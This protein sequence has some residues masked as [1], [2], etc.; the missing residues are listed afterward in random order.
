AFRLIPPSV[1]VLFWM[2]VWL[3][4]KEI[5]PVMVLPETSSPSPV[6]SIPPVIV[7]LSIE[8]LLRN[9]TVLLIVQ[10]E[11]VL[12]SSRPSDPIVQP[13]TILPLTPPRPRVSVL[14][15]TVQPEPMP[16][17]M[18][19]AWQF[20]TVLEEPTEKPSV[21][22]MPVMWLPVLKLRFVPI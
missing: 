16:S 4:K 17:P 3:P 20:L 6:R 14:F 13:V 10:L 1:T 15:V 5:G 19:P 11:T 9:D 22:L 18:P 8:L 12:P 21:K 2:V 7:L